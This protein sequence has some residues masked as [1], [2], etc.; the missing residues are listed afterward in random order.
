MSITSI[1]LNRNVVPISYAA[2]HLAELIKRKE[3][4]IITQKGYPTGIILPVTLFT[5]LQD[6]AKIDPDRLLSGFVPDAPESA[7]DEV[8]AFLEGVAE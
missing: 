8:D 5:Q 6:L 3:I 1:D 4:V 7:A 2:A